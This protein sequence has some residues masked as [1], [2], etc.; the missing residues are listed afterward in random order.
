[1]ER[2]DDIVEQISRLKPRA[3]PLLKARI[4][5]AIECQIYARDRHGTATHDMR[6]PFTSLDQTVSQNVT[7]MRNY[8]WLFTYVLVILLSLAR[9]EC[10][11]ADDRAPNAA[12]KYWQAFSTMPKMGDKLEQKLKLACSEDGFDDPVDQQLASLI[13][14]SQYAL[15]MLDRGVKISGCD[16]GIDMR[17][18]GAETLLPH[19]AKARTLAR[20]ALVRARYYFEQGDLDMGV[21]DILSTITIAR[22]VSHDGTLIGLLVGQSIEMSA[23][24]VLAAYLPIIDDTSLMAVS[25]RFD[26]LPRM[27]ST[28]SAVESEKLFIDWGVERIKMHGDGRLLRFCETLTTSKQQ[29]E[30]LLIAGGNREQFIRHLESLRPLYDDGIRLLTLPP[31]DFEQGAKELAQRLEQNPVS[32]FVFPN[33]NALYKANAIYSCHWS[34]LVAAINIQSSGRTALQSHQDPYGDGPFELIATTG[35][36]GSVGGSTYRLRSRLK[37]Q[38]GQSVQLTVGRAAR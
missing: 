38:D 2:L 35:S 8:R 11:F 29:A 24:E 19:L 26:S 10:L 9:A 31:V 17:I 28:A 22:H 6:S 4:M 25:A 21:V 13:E 7:R 3:D 18:D 32:R 37:R 12:L 5:R 20:L 34:L 23:G 36:G 16:W 33:F 30:E 14:Q 27:T 1:M 15:H